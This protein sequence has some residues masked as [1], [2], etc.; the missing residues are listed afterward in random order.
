MEHCFMGK[1][2]LWNIC[3]RTKRYLQSLSSVSCSSFVRDTT[4]SLL[5]FSLSLVL[6]Q[7]KLYVCSITEYFSPDPNLVW[8]D[9]KIVDKILDE[10]QHRIIVA[11]ADTAGGVKYKEDICLGCADRD[12]LILRFGDCNK[13]RY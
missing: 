8:S 7:I 6:V 10:F 3:K 4:D 9:I 1:L 13:N 11:L 12:S 2:T 5:Y